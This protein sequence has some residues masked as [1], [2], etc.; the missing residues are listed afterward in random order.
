MAA[1]LPVAGPSASV[2]SG[3]LTWARGH[4]QV[5]KPSLECLNK[6]RQSGPWGVFS[7]ASLQ[8]LGLKEYRLALVKIKPEGRF[9]TRLLSVQ[10]W[11]E[12]PH[13][14]ELCSPVRRR[15]HA[16]QQSHVR[17]GGRG[18]VPKP[19]PGPCN[20]MAQ[21]CSDNEQEAEPAPSL[22]VHFGLKPC[23]SIIARTT[24]T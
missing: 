10:S 11:E 24:A 21:E 14:S 22:P 5:S 4:L 19:S 1:T 8:P 16:S 20:V 9:Q 2:F 7:E 13:W 6:P 3:L 18:K 23:L 15:A 12:Q 17:W